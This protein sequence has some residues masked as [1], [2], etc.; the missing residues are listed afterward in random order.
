MTRRQIKILACLALASAALASAQTLQPGDYEVTVDMQL[1]G[2]ET[3]TFTETTCLTPEGARDFRAFLQD[4][5][6]ADED[7]THSNLRTAGNKTT[8]DSACG[9]STS[10]SELTT[11]AGDT[12]TVVVTTNIGGETF[13]AD[14]RA[15]RVAATCT[16]EDDD[17]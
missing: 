10:V 3:T 11:L 16:V 14:M 17:E 9:D 7:C 6:S 12:F 13:K 1:P 2:S 5:L 15:K 8:W 4:S